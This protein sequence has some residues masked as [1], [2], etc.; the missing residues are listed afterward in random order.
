M[1]VALGEQSDAGGENDEHYSARALQMA[2]QFE[3]EVGMVCSN[4]TAKDCA[5][6]K[7][8]SCCFSTP[9]G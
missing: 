2:Q 7:A 9:S 3:D 6:P 8:E 4:A 1:L 5:R